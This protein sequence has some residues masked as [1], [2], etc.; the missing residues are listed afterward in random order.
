VTLHFADLH[1]KE[2]MLHFDVAI[3]NANL[4]SSRFVELRRS[5]HEKRILIADG[6]SQ[7]DPTCDAIQTNS[8][9]TTVNTS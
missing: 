6:V 7:F 3:L 9:P 1:Q 4:K 2:R 5:S 8:S